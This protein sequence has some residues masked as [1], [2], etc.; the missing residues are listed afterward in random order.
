MAI[1][2]HLSFTPATVVLYLLGH[3][4][5]SPE[6]STAM[7]IS[8]ISY[9][10]VLTFLLTIALSLTSCSSPGN[11]NSPDNIKMTVTIDGLQKG[12]EAALVLSLSPSTDPAAKPLLQQSVT[13]D[14]GSLTTEITAGL[15]DG[16]YLLLLEA[17]EKYFRDPKGYLFAVTQSQILNPT[18]RNV[19]FNLLPQ[20]ESLVAEAYISLSGPPKVGGAPPLFQGTV[21]P[22]EATYLPGERVDVRLSLTNTSLDTITISSYPSE[23]QVAP[24]RD[25]D[26]I[27]FSRAGGTQ[28]LD[29]KP[30]DT[31]TLEFTWDQKDSEG[32]QVPA[33]WYAVTFK[34]INVIQG[35]RRNTINPGAAV[36]IQYPQGAMEKTIELEQSRR[37]NG[38]TVTLERVELTTT[39]MTVYAFG[40]LPNYKPPP[41]VSP[42]IRVFAEFSLNGDA[43]KPAGSAGQ[44]YFENGTRFIWRR[45]IDPV[46][47][48]AKELTFSI[49]SITLRSD[50]GKADRLV[51][52]PWE[53]AV[54]LQ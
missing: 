22:D 38:V 2:P 1:C 15:K 18:G 49:T 48:D 8:R 43:I 40:M 27:L 21:V 23:I 20:P 29:I 11:V 9:F 37:A 24:F 3:A 28:P 41:A 47:S 19:I 7:K 14:G 52:G 45:Y 35:D 10:A 44:Q 53:F 36:L 16:S 5:S 34:D 42:F 26:Q 17:P 51:E 50:P 33:G 25:R 13:G 12:E 54:S 32:K 30:G 4:V 39:G 46:P 31:A 6:R